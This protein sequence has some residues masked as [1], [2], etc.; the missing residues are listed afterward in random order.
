MIGANTS[1][2]NAHTLIT[3]VASFRIWRGLLFHAARGLMPAT[4]ISRLILSKLIP[5]SV[6][7]NVNGS[8]AF[9]KIM[10]HYKMIFLLGGAVAIL[11]SGPTNFSCILRYF[12]LTL[13][14]KK[15]FLFLLLLILSSFIFSVT[16]PSS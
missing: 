9:Y 6:K 16:F 13:S 4:I 2:I 7:E 15:L 8:K 3:T 5:V 10:S 12:S 11:V 14:A 1:R